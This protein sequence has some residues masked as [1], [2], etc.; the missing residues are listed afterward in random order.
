[1]D[2]N[3][4]S[5]STPAHKAVKPPDRNFCFGPAEP[6]GGKPVASRTEADAAAPCRA[7]YSTGDGRW[8]SHSG[9]GPLMIPRC[10][11]GW[12]LSEQQVYG[13]M[14]QSSEFEDHVRLKIKVV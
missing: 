11:S 14:M 12:R 5:R 4:Y 1:M 8:R 13:V 6:E 7:M 3:D 2:H 9:A 10:I